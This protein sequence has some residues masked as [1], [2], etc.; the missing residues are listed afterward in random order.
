M[1]LKLKY[2][3]LKVSDF[4]KFKK[5]FND[6][7]KKNISLR[8]FKWR[9]FSDKS[10]F[11]YGVFNFSKLIA[12]AGMVSNKLNTPKKEIIFSRHSSMV[13]KKYRNNKIFSN[14][15]KRV[16]KDI[17][18]N[19]FLLAMWPNKNN[20]S[21]FSLNKK[22]I[23]K[24]KY[25][26]YKI[27]SKQFTKEKTKNLKIDHLIKLKK[28]MINPKDLFFKD[29]KYFKKRYLLYRKDDYF[30][31]ELELNNTRSFFIMKC[32]KNKSDL[33]YVILEHFGSKK[34]E[35]THFSYLIAE[36]KNLIFLS[37]KKIN[38]TKL[39]LLNLIYF[40]IGFIKNFNLKYK[41][42]LIK[43]EISLG[44]TDIFITLNNKFN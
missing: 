4:N 32:Q 22:K 5:L 44:D 8:F 25:F 20:F 12:N 19:F 40:K 3:K 15:L 29:Y 36:Y 2:K 17:S 7:F 16:K 26:L 11:C 39:K 1:I 27:V 37:N 35:S 28:F 6:T 31:N 30:I 24:K 13:L 42:L 14:L 34:I 33:S 38:D 23:I 21:N 9:Y 18:K 41:N 10:S 43:K